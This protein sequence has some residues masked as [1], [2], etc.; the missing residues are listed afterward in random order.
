MSLYHIVSTQTLFWFESVF[1]KLHNSYVVLVMQWIVLWLFSLSLSL[2]PSDFLRGT[3]KQLMPSRAISLATAGPPLSL[4]SALS[5]VPFTATFRALWSTWLASTLDCWRW[6][7]WMI[8]TLSSVLWRKGS[9]RPA[10]RPI[11]QPLPGWL[12]IRS[13]STRH[14][15][16]RVTMQEHRWVV[17]FVHL[18][19]W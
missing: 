2:F 1:L 4:T 5:L 12:Q 3:P 8:Y 19:E 14:Q 17:N 9:R 18:H 6:A 13:F 16:E 11:T 10:I 7:W 15:M